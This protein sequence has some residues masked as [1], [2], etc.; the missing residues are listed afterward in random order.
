MIGEGIVQETWF[1]LIPKGCHDS[2]YNSPDNAHNIA[3]PSSRLPYH[4]LKI[5]LFGGPLGYTI[6]PIYPPVDPG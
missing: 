4:R 6:H 2:S 3:G 5:G 1:L